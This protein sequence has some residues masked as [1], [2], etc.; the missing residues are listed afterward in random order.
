MEFQSLCKNKTWELVM[1]P[2]G[3]KEISSKWMFKVKEIVDGL[4]E[5]YKA[6]LVAKGFLQKYGVDLRRRSRRWSSW[7]RSESF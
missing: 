6:R 5:R 1:F 3:R 4:I 7:R 2:R